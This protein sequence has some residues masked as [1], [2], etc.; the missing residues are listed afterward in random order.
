MSSK[1]LIG[2]VDDERN[3]QATLAAILERRGY[4]SA[5]A[6]TGRPPRGKSC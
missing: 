6:F 4:G 3:I 5:S 2:I 1:P